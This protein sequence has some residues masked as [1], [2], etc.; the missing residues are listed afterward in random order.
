MFLREEKNLLSGST[1]I[2]FPK[3]ILLHGA[4]TY[5]P[6]IQLIL[7]AKISST[8]LQD[9]DNPSVKYLLLPRIFRPFIRDDV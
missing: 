4:F 7:S 5:H 3:R 2:G 1:N 6:S 9:F 8:F